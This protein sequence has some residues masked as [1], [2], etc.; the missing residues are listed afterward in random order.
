[1]RTKYP[2]TPHLPWSPGATSD[3]VRVFDLSGFEG[4]RVVATEKLDGENTSLYR[5]GMHARSIDSRHHPSRDWVKG[6]Q[7][8]I[9]YEIPEG[10]RLCGENLYARHSVAYYELESYFYLFSVWNEGDECL[11]WEETVTLAKLFELPTPSVLFDGPWDVEAVRS[12]RVD[13]EICEG[14]VVRLAE[15][16][17]YQDFARSVAKWVRP[18]HVQTDDHWMHGTMVPNGLRDSETEEPS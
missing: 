14:Y 17:A 11:S 8:R 4:R 5:D 12:L 3:D 10:W 15:G 2:R 7:A 13:T 18:S 6:L 9:G 16:F 1:M